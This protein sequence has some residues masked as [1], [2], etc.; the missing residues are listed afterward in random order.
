MMGLSRKQWL[1]LLA[2]NALILCRWGYEFGRN[3][4]MQILGYA[5]FLSQPDLYP[6]DHYIQTMHKRVPNERFMVSWLL[7][8]TDAIQ[9]WF[10]FLAFLATNILIGVQL[11][12]IMGQFFKRDLFFFT[13]L[14]FLFIPFYHINLGHN[15][16]AY[17]A[18]FVSQL[19]NLMLLYAL[20]R[21]LAERYIH[22]FLV[23]GLSGILQ[24]VLAVHFAVS[25]GALLGWWTISQKEKLT[26]IITI[27]AYASYA[28]TG[29][30]W[31]LFL[32]FFFEESSTVSNAE[33]FQIL[34]EFR[35]P[36]HY[37]PAAFN[38]KIGLFLVPL[39]LFGGYFFSRK[40]KGLQG[41][42]IFTFVGL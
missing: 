31:I 22:S 2:V 29:G 38:W 6:L 33:F 15:E 17:S 24:P 7:S 10:C 12:R 4:Q 30:I 34:F 36:H 37:L 20:E 8:W 32:K 19:V 13:G 11:F 35:A 14:L 27:K 23:I 5:H 9:E 21:F 16:L 40:S 28:L 42:F 18:F 1:L 41:Y 26:W 3:D 25:L 39:W